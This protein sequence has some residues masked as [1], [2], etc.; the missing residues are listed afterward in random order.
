MRASF[1]LK[2]VILY[3]NDVKKTKHFYEKLL[4]FPIR[5]EAGTYVEFSTGETI[6][7]CNTRESGR[8]I[9]GLRIPDE[10]RS[11]TFEL[12]VTVADV[13]VAIDEFR[14]A[15]VTI[16][17]EPVTKPWGQEVAYVADPDGHYIEVC[18]PMD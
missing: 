8:E 13:K 17:K 1:H 15:G 6:L 14:S 4:G 2:Y 12:G 3:V 16:L 7:S 5:M 10:S 9:T 18:S 11:Q